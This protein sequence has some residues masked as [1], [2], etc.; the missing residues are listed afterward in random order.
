MRSS[1]ADVTL[2]YLPF[3]RNLLHQTLVSL[4]AGDTFR[5]YSL[6]PRAGK[7]NPFNVTI[8]LRAYLGQI[9]TASPGIWETPPTNKVNQR[10]DRRHCSPGQNGHG[11][12]ERGQR[13]GNPANPACG[14]SRPP[15]VRPEE[16]PTR[17]AFAARRYRTA[18]KRDV[19]GR[20]P[21]GTTSQ[22]RGAG[23]SLSLLASHNGRREPLF[24]L[25]PGR[26]YF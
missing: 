6:S 22:G 20:R 18:A 4:V 2:P 13:G 19:T 11:W 7:F 1:L 8:E 16:L 14:T 15:R 21:V 9:M 5:A 23:I 25:L 3:C 24:L 26:L 17:R 10:M 12:R